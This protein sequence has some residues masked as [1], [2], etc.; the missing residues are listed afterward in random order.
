MGETQTEKKLTGTFLLYK[1]LLY[2]HGKVKNQG[3]HLILT[4][5]SPKL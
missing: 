3:D 2:L 4:N 5:L 1:N